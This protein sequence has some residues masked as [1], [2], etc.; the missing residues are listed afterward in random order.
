MAGHSKFANIKHRKDRQDAKR[1]KVFTKLGR[2]LAV[3]VKT[4]G[5]DP[6]TNSRLRD[7]IAKAKGANMANDTIERSIKKAAGELDNVN[8]EEITYEGYGPCGIAVIVKA[9]TDNRT[10]TVANVR[11]A[12]AKGGGNLGQSGSV[13]FQFDHVGQIAVEKSDIVDEDELMMVALEAG[14]RDFAAHDEGFEIITDPADFSAVREAVEAGGF[15]ILSAE[16]TMLPKLTTKI[17][18]PEDIKKMNKIL[19]FLEEDDD[20]QDVYHNWEV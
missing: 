2:E 5:P 15:A 8:Y 20:V 4:G 7:I 14:A 3:A 6:E 11:F 16:I 10:R 13:A 1:G 17:D 9:L 12:F 18:N 19:D